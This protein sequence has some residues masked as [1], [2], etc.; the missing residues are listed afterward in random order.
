VARLE[1][2]AGAKEL[3]EYV[4]FYMKCEE[5]AL[6][7]SMEVIDAQRKIQYWPA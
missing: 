7:C 2:G 3:R 4:A 6:G 5:K 1:P